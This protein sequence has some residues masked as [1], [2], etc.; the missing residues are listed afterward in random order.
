MKFSAK[1]IRQIPG[2]RVFLAVAVL[3]GLIAG[4]LVIAQ[5]FYLSTIISEVFVGARTLSQERVAIGILLCVIVA[6]GLISWGEAIVANR[7]A[8]RMKIAVREKVLT[9]LFALGPNYTRGERSGELVN[10]IVEG[11]E[12][13]EP[14]LS[15]YLPQVY[16]AV[17][18][19]IMMLIV[20]F[21]IDFPSSIVLLVMIPVLP[22]LLAIAG[23]MAGK[24]TGRHWQ[25]LS[26]MSAHFLDVLQGLT[27]LKIFGRGKS[28][29]ER[30]RAVSEQFRETTMGTLKIAFLSAFLLEEAATIGT[31]IIAIEIGL[32]LLIGE[33]PFQAALFIL[34]IAP[35]F[36]LPLRQ[37]GAKYHAGMTGTAALQRINEILDTPTGE[38]VALAAASEASKDVG[39]VEGIR[40]ENVS[41]AYDGQRAALRDVSFEMHKGQRVA[42]V[43]ASGAG[44]STIAQLLL[45]FISADSGHILVNGREIE[46]IAMREWRE[47]VA[48]VPQHAYL[49][50]ASVAENI[51]LGCAEATREQIEAAA[52][53]ARADRF[54]ENLPQGYETVIGERG[55]R[56]SGG[57]AQRISLARAFLKDAPILIL[58][59]ATANLDAENEAGIVETLRELEQGRTVLLIAHH[60][61]TISRAE[62]IVVMERGAIVEAGT[63]EELMRRAGRYERLMHMYEREK[64]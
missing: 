6:R 50:N 48:W 4:A 32:R 39:V 44:K 38:K 36:F 11:V 21:F 13:L 22:F 1:M 34:L 2:V 49:F 52:K 26:L 14:Y 25:A 54:I 58:D 42:L 20:I 8:A 18:V 30:V 29:V 23:M 43:G 33:M 57:E 17:L 31:A 16:L 37:L 64:A 55:A 7:M 35:E 53:S 3:V 45:R 62:R 60:L 47:Q 15:Q 46:S 12:A 24:E 63:H 59:E 9:R 41:Y 40:F 27:T 28:E 19:P 5:N 56:L 10:T 51:G 61:S